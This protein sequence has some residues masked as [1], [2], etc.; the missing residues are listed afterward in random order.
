[1]GGP[2]GDDRS[3][4]AVLSYVGRHGGGTIAVSSQSSAAAAIIDK[5]AIVAGIGGFSGRES[6]VSVSWLSQEVSSGRIR[7]VLA[8]STAG[9]ARLP[10]DTRVGAKPAISAVTRACRAVAVPAT[11]SRAG[12]A[13]AS[14][15]LY[16]CQGRASALTS[17]GTTRG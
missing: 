4:A 16:D 11:T 15:K 6:E 13:S 8:E 7:W 2:F 10:G 3:I 9:R 14:G 12:A 1:M 17:A 5:H